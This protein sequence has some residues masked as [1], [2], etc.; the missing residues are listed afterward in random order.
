[1]ASILIIDDDDEFRGAL[2][3]MLVAGGHAVT[4]AG[5]GL[6]GTKLFRA[7][8]TDL[9]LIDMVMPHSGLMAIQVLRDQHPG[10]KMIAMSGA[11]S[12]RLDYARGFGALRSLAKPFTPQQLAEAIATT[13]AAPP[14]KPSTKP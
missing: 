14:A 7:A 3:Q 13:L 8:P 12:H 5:D 9:I 6:E 10:L 4:V 11:G 1:M 2:E